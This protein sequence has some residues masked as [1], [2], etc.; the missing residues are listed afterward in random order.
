VNAKFRVWDLPT[1]LFHWTLALLVLGQWGTAE[2]GWLDMQ[3]HFYF[4]Y[5]LLAL[6]L[7]RLLWGFVGSETARFT[8]FLRGPEAVAKFLGEVLRPGPERRAGHNPLGGW[9]VM[10]LIVL[11]AVQGVSGLYSSD[12]IALFGPLSG[13]VSADVVELM[14]EIHAFDQNL[15]LGVIVVH[16]IAVFWH[17]LYKKET[18]I[19]AMFSG[20][21]ELP[22][23]PALRFAP[24]WL[25]WLIAAIAAAIVWGVVTWPW[26]T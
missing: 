1:R 17:M 19:R 5:A 3:W 23:D 2:W 22:V 12:E 9:A 13:T 4:G 10:L 24:A 6:L 14:N 11:L 26:G 18:L 15:I 7:F 20:R 21:K 16:V 25:A 8:H